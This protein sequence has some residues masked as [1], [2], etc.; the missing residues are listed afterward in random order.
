MH[1]NDLGI[2]IL[3]FPVWEPADQEKGSPTGLPLG[4]LWNPPCTLWGWLLSLL[5]DSRGRGH[6][7]VCWRS[8][9]PE[10]AVLGFHGP[11]HP[12]LTQAGRAGYLLPCQVKPV[13][14]GETHQTQILPPPLC[15]C[16]DAHLASGGLWKPLPVLEHFLTS[17]EG[18]I[19]P[20]LTKPGRH[21]TKLGDNP[22]FYSLV[23]MVEK[24]WGNTKFPWRL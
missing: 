17:P 9:A 10:A 14:Y 13:F 15:P 1:S 22:V 24:L 7:T 18:G 6:H 19:P 4:P 20:L 23:A 8:R 21:S 2:R 16:Q 11:V 12:S 3:P 5:P